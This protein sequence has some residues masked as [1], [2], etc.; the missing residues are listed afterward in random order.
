MKTYASVE[1]KFFTFIA[2]ALN[3]MELHGQIAI[4]AALFP[5]VSPHYSLF[6]MLLMFQS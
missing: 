5:T 2:S 4:T 6:R 1:V 3:G